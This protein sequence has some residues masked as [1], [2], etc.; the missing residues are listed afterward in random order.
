MMEE[1]EQERKRGISETRLLEKAVRQRWPI[2]D[3]YRLAIMERQARIA[4]DEDASN[5]EATS[6]AKCLIS[7][8]RQNQMDDMAHDDLLARQPQ[9]AVA[10]ASTGMSIQNAQII[11]TCPDNN[12]GPN[13][14]ER[15]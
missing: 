1:P 11:L 7:A 12:R 14:I 10:A 9:S 6:A 13:R 3:E 15:D 5:R 4:I 8:E 2:P